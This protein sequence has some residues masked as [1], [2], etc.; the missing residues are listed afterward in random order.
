MEF[1]PARSDGPSLDEAYRDLPNNFY[2]HLIHPMP[3]AQV[4]EAFHQV[5][6]NARKASWHEYEV[7]NAWAELHLSPPGL[8]AG[9]V[10]PGHRERMLEL[11]TELG[12][13]CAADPEESVD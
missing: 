13:A 6:W 4:A 11:F 3:V 10:A 2:A 12:I 5:G 9:V 1:T 7:S 8:I